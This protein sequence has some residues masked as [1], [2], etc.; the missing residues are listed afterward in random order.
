MFIIIIVSDVEL[1]LLS[2]YYAFDTTYHNI[3][4]CVYNIIIK[5]QLE[6][7]RFYA[8]KINSKLTGLTYLRKWLY[9]NV[10]IYNT[11]IV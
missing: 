7:G 3:C 1:L 10:A 5:P 6:N 8:P 9:V 11:G 2:Y 4:S